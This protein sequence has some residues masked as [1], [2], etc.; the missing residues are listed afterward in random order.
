MTARTRIAAATIFARVA[1]TSALLTEIL[2]QSPRLNRIITAISTTILSIGEEHNEIIDKELTFET[3]MGRLDKNDKADY[4]IDAFTADENNVVISDEVREKEHRMN[5]INEQ[6]KKS[7][8][9]QKSPSAIIVTTLCSILR[10]NSENSISPL[11][12]LLFM[13]DDRKKASKDYILVF[14]IFYYLFICL[15][16]FIIYKLF[17]ILICCKINK[18]ID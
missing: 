11:C 1:S 9:L 6:L 17:N 16:L 8:Y 15:F 14:I 10:N 5:F 2:R 13:N 4:N 12:Q 7:L 3:G 18:K